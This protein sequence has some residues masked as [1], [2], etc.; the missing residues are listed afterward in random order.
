M[1]SQTSQGCPLE[2][3]H[4]PELT[5]VLAKGIVPSGIGVD[6][7][8]KW[9]GNPTESADAVAEMLQLT[10][11]EAHRRLQYSSPLLFPVKKTIKLGTHRSPKQLCRAILGSSSPEGVPC[12][13]G[14]WGNDILRRIAVARSMADVVLYFATVADIGFPNGAPWSAIW[15]KLDELGYAKCPAEVG[16]QLRLQ[17]LDQPLGEWVWVVME[18]IPDSYGYPFVFSVERNE[19]GLWLYGDD[20]RPGCNL[21]ADALLAFV[22]KS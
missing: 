17:Y 2:L 16:P 11:V 13:I 10:P 4:I 8:Q 3:R 15:S 21:N 22:R 19:D 6:H 7:A 1:G 18:P 5:Y 12:K 9:I 14:E 20:G